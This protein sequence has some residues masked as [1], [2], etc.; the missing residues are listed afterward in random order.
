MT[1][2]RTKS[3]RIKIDGRNFADILQEK[4]IDGEDYVMDHNP[5][6]AVVRLKQLIIGNGSPGIAGIVAAHETFIQ[7]MKGGFILIGFV[8]M[9]NIVGLVIVIIKLFSK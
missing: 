5:C 7:R 1:F 2:V 3:G 9:A 8:G 6:E 4:L